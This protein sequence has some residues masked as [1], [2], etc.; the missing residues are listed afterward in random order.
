VAA[1]DLLCN[2]EPTA[3]NTASC[4]ALPLVAWAST[5]FSLRYRYGE[6]VAYAGNVIRNGGNKY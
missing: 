4:A 6:N 5:H 2:R 3:H 1:A